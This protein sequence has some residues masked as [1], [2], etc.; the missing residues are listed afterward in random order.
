[1][2]IKYCYRAYGLVFSSELQLPELESAE[3]TPDVTIRMGKIPESLHEPLGKGLR[4]QANVDEFLLRLDGLAGFHVASGRTVMVEPYADP[5][6]PEIR[7]YLLGSVFSALLQ[8][9]GYLA[10][11]GSAIEMRGSGILFAGERGAGK[12]TLA[13]AF[14]DKGYRI[15]ADDVCAIQCG[16]NSA[17]SIVPSFPGL[18]LWRDSVEKLGKDAGSLVPVKRDTEKY[19]VGTEN[20]YSGESAVLSEIYVLGSHDSAAIAIREQE[21]VTALEALIKSTYRYRYLR[22]QGLR[23]LHFRQCA[24]VAGKVK[25]YE[26]LRPADSFRLSDLAT[27]IEENCGRRNRLPPA[28]SSWKRAS[29]GTP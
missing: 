10:L 8:Q 20:R 29:D 1:M 15:L 5:A 19:R 21:G 24:A 14:H 4:F 9:R 6:D 13:A 2:G 25:V 22:G 18:K 7:L 27:A 16:R 28:D 3:G 11:H 23:A 17:P 12:S 26:V